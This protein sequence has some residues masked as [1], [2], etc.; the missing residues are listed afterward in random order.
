MIYG[1][2]REPGET[3][4]IAEK[5][6]EAPENEVYATRNENPP[7]GSGAGILR[8]GTACAMEWGK[9][10]AAATSR[11]LKTED[12]NHKRLK[13]NQPQTIERQENTNGMNR[14]ETINTENRTATS[15]PTPKSSFRRFSV[16]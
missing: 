7:I 6:L 15:N 4:G 13:P 10:Q 1:H 2:L 11:R 8:C 3:S 14:D 16:V 5:E 9:G 12:Q